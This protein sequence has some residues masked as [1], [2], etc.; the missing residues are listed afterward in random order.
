MEKHIQV[1]VKTL[2]DYHLESFLR[3]PYKFYYRHILTANSNE[4]YWRQYVQA[5]INK[6]VQ[7][8]YSLP[9][10]A[11][12]QFGALKL[13]NQYWNELNI[14]LFDSKVEYYLVLAKVTDH[15]L[16]FLKQ[17]QSSKIFLYE[18]QTAF[19]QELETELSLTIDIGEWSKNSFIIRKY[20]LE[21]DQEMAKLYNYLITV[22]SHQAFERLPERIEIINL[23]TGE[24]Y[25]YTPAK[26]DVNEG[27]LYL[28]SMKDLLKHPYGYTKTSSAVECMNCEFNQKCI[29]R[30]NEDASNKRIL[31]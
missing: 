30:D 28:K 18:K 2:T 24:Q 6:I 3:C 9:F 7:S 11:Q 4:L 31:H 21:T 19:I 26:K 29:H 25:S 17:N 27:L 8:Y 23:M 14:E 16:K 20:L 22:F 5:T 10:K 15:L 13:I 12:T 1:S